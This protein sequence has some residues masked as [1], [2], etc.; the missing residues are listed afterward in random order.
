MILVVFLFLVGKEGGQRLKGLVRGRTA[1]SDCRS[2]PL[3]L[4]R[5]VALWALRSKSRV[6][7]FQSEVQAVEP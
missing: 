4:M 1:T 2:R 3:D 7:R 5:H 6:P